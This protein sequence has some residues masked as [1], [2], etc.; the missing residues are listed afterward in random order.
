MD[1]SRDA[2]G[3]YSLYPSHLLLLFLLLGVALASVGCVPLRDMSFAG[4]GAEIWNSDLDGDLNFSVSGFS[5]TDIDLSQTLGI[6]PDEN[7]GVYRGSVALGNV[8]LDVKYLEVAYDG[9]S[10]LNQAVTFNGQ[11]FNVSTEVFSDLEVRTASGYLKFGL[12]DL[13]YL[14]I[15]P[16]IGVNYI[17]VEAQLASVTPVALTVSDEIEIPVPVVG[18]AFNLDIPILSDW[19]GFFAEGEIAGLFADYQE[20][21]GKFI[22]L[23]AVGGFK[24]A[25]FF[26]LGG[27]YRLFDVDFDD[28]SGDD[29]N[30]ATITLDGPFIFA[31]LSF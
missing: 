7:V 21:D 22:D 16:L 14:N 2:L 30:E 12:I 5:G 27:G 10:L 6:D 20:I 4:G 1:D 31:E 29:E 18:I 15:G 19:L 28:D 25:H 9:Q 13:P 26:R 24:I 8:I 11:T 3:R 23:S 17:D